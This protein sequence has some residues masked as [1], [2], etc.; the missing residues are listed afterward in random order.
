MSF[1]VSI[2][3]I[4]SIRKKYGLN[5]SDSLSSLQLREAMLLSSSLGRE[6]GVRHNNSQK[7]VAKSFLF[8]YEI[9]KSSLGKKDVVLVVHG[10]H[11]SKNVYERLPQ[12]GKRS[13]NGYK[14]A[15]KKGADECYL[16]Q[17]KVFDYLKKRTLLYHTPFEYTIIQYTFVNPRSRDHDNQYSTIK[18]LQDTLVRLGLIIDD[19]QE[20][21]FVP[22]IEE[23]SGKN[24]DYRI[25]IKLSPVSRDKFLSIKNMY[26]K[27][28]I[29]AC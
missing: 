22:D 4:N 3:A 21:I 2:K 15:F 10:K 13:Q 17:K 25:I 20:N 26:K 1:N 27:T 11:I 14:S 8:R 28:R 5:K 29:K 16:T 24:D 9:D 12:W 23:V 6:K 18:P 19:K 7:Q